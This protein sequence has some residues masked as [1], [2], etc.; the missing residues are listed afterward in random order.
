[1]MEYKQNKQVIDPLSQDECLDKI[2]HA[3]HV[4]CLSID[5]LSSVELGGPQD[6][7]RIALTQALIRAMNDLDDVHQRLNHLFSSPPRTVPDPSQN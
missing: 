5:V 4:L 7:S 3:G 1:M 6:R 2:T